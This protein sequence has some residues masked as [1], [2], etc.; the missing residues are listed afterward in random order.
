MTLQ[1]VDRAVFRE[2]LHTTFDI[3]T[4]EMLMERIFC[5]WEKGFEGLPIRLEG[6]IMGL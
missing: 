6:W 2:L 5:A 3:I 1:G 4:E